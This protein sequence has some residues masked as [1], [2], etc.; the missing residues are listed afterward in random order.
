MATMA[1]EAGC[2]PRVNGKMIQT[3]KYNGMIVSLVG[4]YESL[5]MNGSL[6]PFKAADDCVVHLSVK[7]VE[8]EMLPIATGPTSPVVEI[9]GAVESN[10]QVLVRVFVGRGRIGFLLRLHWSSS[11]KDNVP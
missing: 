4:R 10:N 6:L 3:G 8:P 1:Q 7:E 5:N 2:Y 9:V 11:W